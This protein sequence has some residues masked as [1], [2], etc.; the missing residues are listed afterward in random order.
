MNFPRFFLREPGLHQQLAACIKSN[1]QFLR[2]NGLMLFAYDV[3]CWFDENPG[4]SNVRLTCVAR[5]EVLEPGFN[6]RHR[7][8]FK[9]TGIAKEPLVSKGVSFPEDQAAM[10]NYASDRLPWQLIADG[11]C[12]IQR[13]HP[14]LAQLLASEEDD[15][16]AVDAGLYRLALDISEQ[17]Q[18]PWVSHSLGLADVFTE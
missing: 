4:L 1:D 18:V 10:D 3:L 17:F 11:T 13:S 9:L 15:A 16:L 12:D 14:A 5:A 6:V 7:H 8:H 2:P